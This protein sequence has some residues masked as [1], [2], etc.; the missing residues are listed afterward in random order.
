MEKGVRE[1]YLAMK[2]CIPGYIQER[3]QA[4]ADEE[5]VQITQITPES[6]KATV[7][8]DGGTYRVVIDRSDFWQSTC[9]CP[10]EDLC[11]HMAAAYFHTYSKAVVKQFEALI[12]PADEVDWRDERGGNRRHGWNE[13]T[14]SIG[15][16]TTLRRT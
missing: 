4:Y 9:D 12:V 2:A 7:M 11:K 15:M 6:L 10:Y 14:M 3:G 5:R 13:L 16:W 1:L 8:G